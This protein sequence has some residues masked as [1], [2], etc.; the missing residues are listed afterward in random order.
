MV[1]ETFSET[2]LKFWKN[3][4]KIYRKLFVHSFFHK[5][6]KPYAN[7]YIVIFM[8]SRFIFENG[9]DCGLIKRTWKLWRTCWIIKLK[10]K[11]KFSKIIFSFKIIKGRSVYYEALVIFSTQFLLKL[12]RC[13]KLN[14]W[15][16]NLVMKTTL[17]CFLYFE[18]CCWGLMII[19]V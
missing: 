7:R 15:W 9:C 5:S 11:N 18:S 16:Q 12:Y 19:H 1:S 2:S 8:V 13:K 14:T 17:A 4:F 6:L 3:F 10:K